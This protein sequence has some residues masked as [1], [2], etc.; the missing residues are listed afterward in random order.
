MIFGMTMIIIIIMM[1]IKMNRIIMICLF[2]FI[3]TMIRM[4]KLAF[5]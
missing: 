4:T 5:S 1:M 2:T 3:I